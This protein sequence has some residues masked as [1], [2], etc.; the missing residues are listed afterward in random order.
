MPTF[1]QLEYLVAIADAQN[2]RRAAAAVHVSQPTLSQQLRVLEAELGI[3]LVERQLAGAHLTPIGRDIADRARKLLVERQDI[4]DL[5][6]TARD[7]AIGTIRFGVTPTLGPYLLPGV[8]SELARDH[9]GLRLYIREGIPDEQALELARG[10][11]DMIVGPLPIHGDAL[12][13]EPLFREDLVLVSSP[14]H[15]LA[16]RAFVSADDLRGAEV[17]SLDPRHHLHRQGVILCERYGMVLLRD[18]EGTSLDSL[19]Q[20]A[21]TGLGLAILPRLYLCS[22]VGGDA[23]VRI[24]RP[25]GWNGHR[26]IAACWRENAPNGNLYAMIARRVSESAA[27]IMSE[28]R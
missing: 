1:R 16:N 7:R 22:E 19:R 26:T 21:A 9:A 14:L 13:I 27:R 11:L 8:I 17:L 20:M 23:G 28:P 5:A 6:S 25:D 18:Y 12:S 3:V 15:P 10:K 2:F 24:L 4:C